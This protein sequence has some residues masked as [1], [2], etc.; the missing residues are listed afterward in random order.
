MN[1][2]FKIYIAILVVIFA[3]ILMADRNRPKPIDWRPTYSVNDKIPFGL[4]IF[5]KEVKGLLKN[6]KI[7]RVSAI[8]PYE[9]LDSKYDSD[10]LVENYKIKGTFFNISEYGQ[11]DDQSITEL[12]YFVSHG[13][14][15]FLSMKNFPKSLLDSLKIEINTS[16]PNEKMNSVWMA[17]KKLNPKKYTIGEEEMGNYYFS[18]I[19]TL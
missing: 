10:S 12:F 8:T 7:E 14:N 19:D 4:Y 3:L 13:N 17:N 5:D 11:I 2:T 1:K 6:Q 9:F 18:K 16:F 15:A